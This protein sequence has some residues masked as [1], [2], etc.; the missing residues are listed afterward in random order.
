MTTKAEKT[1]K[2]IV[3]QLP[4]ATCGDFGVELHHVREGQ[5]LSQRSG[6]FL[7][8]PLCTDCHRGPLGVHGDK[9]MLRIRKCTELD[10][11]DETINLVMKR[12]IN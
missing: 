10:L 9:T 2:E 11:V 8:I 12:L 5:G 7:L 4:C 3:A 1:F 6:N